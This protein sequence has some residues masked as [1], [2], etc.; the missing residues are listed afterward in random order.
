ME[1]QKSAVKGL[2][3]VVLRVRDIDRM[4][5][6]Y[7]DTFGLKLLG[8]FETM[9]F[10]Q[11]APGYAGHTQVLALFV[12]FVP[13]N[14]S[15]AQHQGWDPQRTTLH[16]F[17]LAIAMADYELEKERLQELGLDVQTA[18]HGWVH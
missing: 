4:V 2:G 1:Q 5:T 11:I 6:F 14:H 12:E 10:L 7:Q 17:A 15:S 16:H 13:S 3:E 18:E 9:A 8:R